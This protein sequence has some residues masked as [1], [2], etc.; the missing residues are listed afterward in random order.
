MPK[1][2]YVLGTYAF[3]AGASYKI[4]VTA[5]PIPTSLSTTCADAVKFTLMP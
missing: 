4:T 3:V 1:K 5:Q 2:I